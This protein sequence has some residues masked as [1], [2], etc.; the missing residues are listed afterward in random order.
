M[1]FLPMLHDEDRG[2]SFNVLLRADTALE[3]LLPAATSAIASVSPQ[4]SV[5]FS[6]LDSRI[7]ESL[8]RE[9]LMATLSG[10]FGFLAVLLAMIGLYG[11]MSYLVARRKNEIGIRIALGASRRDVVAM[12]LKE[13]GLLAGAGLAIGIALA[14]AAAR[15]VRG[16]LFGLEPGDPATLLIATAALATVALLASSLPARR[17]ASLDPTT[18]LREE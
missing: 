15:A 8:K 12:I 3:G 4:I 17:A 11:V 13:A 7:Y 9:R 6:A 2:D 14:V 1:A 5:R 18:A 10:Y 16:L